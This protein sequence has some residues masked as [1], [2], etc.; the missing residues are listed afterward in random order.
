MHLDIRIPIGLLFTLIGALLVGYGLMHGAPLR[1]TA[2]GWNINAWWGAVL[3]VFGVA[4]L[5]LARRYASRMRNG[6]G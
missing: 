2:A 5:L 4:M 3:I 6:A 1:G